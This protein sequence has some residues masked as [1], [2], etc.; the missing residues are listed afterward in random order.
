MRRGLPAGR[1]L[2]R[3][4]T[5]LRNRRRHASAAWTGIGGGNTWIVCGAASVRNLPDSSSCI[6][7]GKS[8]RIPVFLPPPIA[9]P[10][11]PRHKRP[12]ADIRHAMPAGATGHPASRRPPRQRRRSHE[13]HLEATELP[14]YNAIRGIRP[15]WH[16][17]QDSLGNPALPGCPDRWT[18]SGQWHTGEGPLRP[19]LPDDSPLTVRPAPATENPHRTPASLDT[20]DF[21]SGGI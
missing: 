6:L 11:A 19:G 12:I 5:A 18:Q 7:W 17:R 2:P 1:L 8:S 4:L 3:R 10:V 13:I 9:S 20:Q 15:R 21:A 16:H 14:G